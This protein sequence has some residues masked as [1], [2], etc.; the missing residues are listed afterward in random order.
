MCGQA[1]QVGEELG[2]F[3]GGKRLEQ[4]A[5]GGE[6]GALGGLEAAATP[7]RQLYQAPPAVGGVARAGDQA[8]RLERVEQADQVG[9]VDPQP[10]AEL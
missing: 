4:V 6:G 8:V 7:R 9:R 2:A 5:L 3:G 1:A 10:L